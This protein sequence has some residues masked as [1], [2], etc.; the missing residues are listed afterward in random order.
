MKHPMYDY[1]DVCSIVKYVGE[2]LKGDNIVELVSKKFANKFFDDRQLNNYMDGSVIKNTAS[3]NDDRLSVELGRV[4]ERSKEQD[5]FIHQAIM[6]MSF[7]TVTFL[8]I[9]QSGNICIDGSKYNWD[10]TT[11]R[12]TIDSLKLQQIKF[13][14]HAGAIRTQEMNYFFSYFSGLSKNGVGGLSVHRGNKGGDFITVELDTRRTIGEQMKVLHGESQDFAYQIISILMYIGN[15][16]N[17]RERVASRNIKAKLNRK[18]SCPN[19]KINLI[20]LIQKPLGD[21]PKYHDGRSWESDKTWIVR[22][23]WRSYKSGVAVWIDQYWKGV[24]KKN[25]Q[26]KVYEV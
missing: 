24:G 10:S 17:N 26:E 21:K 9:R 23:H 19:H 2:N 5:Y 7:M 1:P 12:K 11:T 25:I 15:F 13:P 22:G 4:T 6:G 8:A 16:K 18:L 20:T 3:K 14:F